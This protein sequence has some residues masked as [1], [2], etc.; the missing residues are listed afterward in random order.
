[1]LTE[2]GGNLPKRLI[3]LRILTL[4]KNKQLIKFGKEFRAQRNNSK[5]KERKMLLEN[6]IIKIGKLLY[7]KSPKYKNAFWKHIN[8]HKKSEIDDSSAFRDLHNL[9]IAKVVPLD[10]QGDIF[11]FNLS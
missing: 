5:V 7:E 9:I 6:P 2:W 8:V 11:T 1:M 3:L 10:C 4:I